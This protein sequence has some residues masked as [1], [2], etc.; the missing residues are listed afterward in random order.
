MYVHVYHVSVLN[1]LG[2][3]LLH[4]LIFGEYPLL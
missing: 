1:T 2:V 4:L 3:H